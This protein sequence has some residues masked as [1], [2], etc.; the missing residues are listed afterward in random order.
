MEEKIKNNKKKKKEKRGTWREAE[1]APLFLAPADTGSVTMKTPLPALS[2]Y[3][4]HSLLLFLHS[5]SLNHLREPL[6]TVA[7]N[8]YS[9]CDDERRVAEEEGKVEENKEN[10]MR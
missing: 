9:S 1:I 5:L 2:Y 8:Y 3:S 4:V 10:E 7:C 6:P